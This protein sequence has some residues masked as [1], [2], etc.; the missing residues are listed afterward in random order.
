MSPP[1]ALPQ[2]SPGDRIA[3]VLFAL[4][5]F[6]SAFLLF[7]VQPMVSKFILPWFGGSPAVWTTAMLFFQCVLFG[8]YVYAHLLGRQG[9]IRT[10]AA[11]HAL[12]LAIAAWF[13]ASVLPDASLKPTGDE[14]PAARILLILAASVGLP[15]FCLATTGPLL[16]HWFTRT[17]RGDSVFRLYALSN[18]GSFVALLSFPYV[19]EPAFRL[20]EIGRMWTW[21]FWLFAAM[22]AAIALG[23]ARGASGARDTTRAPTAAD[24]APS[25][26]PGWTR[27][28]AWVALPALASLAFI[29]TTDHV[30]HDIAPEPR[31]WITTLALY[32]ATFIL[33]FDHPRWYRP[34]WTAVACVL[35]VLALSGR[36][37]IPG[38][39]GVDWDYGVSALRGLHYAAMFL[40]CLACHGELYRR[41]PADTRRLTEF[42]LFM[43]FGGACGGLFVALVATHL[44]D[45]YHEWPMMLVAALT[46]ACAVLAREVRDAFGERAPAMLGGLAALCLG[47]LVLFWEDPLHLRGAPGRDHERILLDQSRN[48]YGTVSVAERRHPDDPV[49]DHRVFYSGQITHGIQ[50]LDP[51]RRR[52][53]V[54]YYGEDSGI[55]QTLHWVMARQ[56]SARVALVGLGAGTLATYARAT[57]RYDFFEINPEA[58]RVADRW[59]DNVSACLAV[60]KRMIVGDARLKMEQLPADVKYDVIVLDAFTGGSVPTHL[61][62]QEAFAIWR[63]HLADDGFIAINIT[64]GYLNLYPVVRA[65]A[66]ALGMG[67][68][69]RWQASDASRHVRQNQHFVMTHDA[70]YLARHPSVNRQWF[71]AGGALVR[72][73]SL[74]VPGVPLWT[75]HYSSLN[76]IELRD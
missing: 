51:A 29:A 43:S 9:S 15:Y 8:G 17:G 69:N 22:C 52:L 38:W 49:R 11:V 31:L 34:G 19:F 62:T 75:D 45:D 24:A 47:G 5:I 50:Y 23:L 16:Q 41:R 54:T 76:A 20:P 36:D 48:F 28:A 73:E 25:A 72:T 27:R 63:R 26:P 61:L 1:A 12:L 46:L 71:D 13:A 33:A 57:D 66:E 42:Y 2:A 56:P 18:V 21:G 65:Q 53:P 32:L 40:I 55:G 7:Q 6:V 14:A 4:T 44:F 35:A 37:A 39:L 10:Q 59:F 3:V 58:V 67:F 70:A 60:E 30:S 68:R 74:D 64:N